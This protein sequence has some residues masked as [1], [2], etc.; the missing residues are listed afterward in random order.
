[1]GNGERVCFYLTEYQKV[2]SEAQFRVLDLEEL[3]E[4]MH[5]AME[6]IDSSPNTDTYLLRAL[7]KAAKSSSRM[8][9]GIQLKSQ[10][11]VYL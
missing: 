4:D 1:M 9:K 8:A 2:D 5:R 11:G 6:E 7:K 10:A 3:Y